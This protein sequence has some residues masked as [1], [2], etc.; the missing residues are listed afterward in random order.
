MGQLGPLICSARIPGKRGKV[1]VG[2]QSRPRSLPCILG[3]FMTTLRPVFKSGGSMF[4]RIIAVSA[5]VAFV[6]AGSALAAPEASARSFNSCETLVAKYPNGVAQNKKSANRWKNRGYDRPAVNKKVYR[7]NADDLEVS[8]G[9]L[10]G[11]TTKELQS[12]NAK[13]Y[14]ELFQN[15]SSAQIRAAGPMVAPGSPAA[16]Y[17][18]YW[19]NT[20]D[21]VSWREYG[22]RGV[23]QPPPTP[24]PVTQQKTRGSA[25]IFEVGA[26][27]EP[28]TFTF[29]N[30]NRVT[31]WIAT[32]GDVSDRLSAVTGG[33]TAE[34]LTI[35]P[36][37]MY[38]ANNGRAVLTATVTNNRPQEAGV[39]YNA[40]YNAPTGRYPAETTA[41]CVQPGQTAPLYISTEI[42]A[43]GVLPSSWEIR[44]SGDRGM[45]DV[46]S[47]EIILTV[48]VNPATG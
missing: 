47:Q 4:I 17:L 33:T 1:G 29:D 31:S 32:A 13:A 25:V 22:S 35:S 44:F 41:A 20:R 14:A 19:A 7:R 21:A 37:Q 5:A 8:R 45:C 36:L 28:Y 15:G 34:G 46:Y 6:V 24:E 3:G 42:P 23:I 18:D 10:C 26:E 40:V 16:L 48:P 27:K 39:L 43:D 12:A 2:E 30:R 9:V 38:D 11:T